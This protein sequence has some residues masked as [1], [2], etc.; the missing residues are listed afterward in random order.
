MLRKR[1]TGEFILGEMLAR[2]AF[3]EFRHQHE[4]NIGPP[5]YRTTPDLYYEDRAEERYI[6]VYLDGLSNNIHG[7]AQ[8]SQVDRIIREQLEAEGV[9]VIEIAS[10]DLHDP[11]LMR[12]HF[13]RI[14]AKLRRRDIRERLKSDISWFSG[15]E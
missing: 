9:D 8:R 11:E 4:I 7:N 15:G 13:K 12:T 5:Y 6:A 1:N 2:A 14:A 10:S 3:P